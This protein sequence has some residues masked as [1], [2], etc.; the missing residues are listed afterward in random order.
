M[1]PYIAPVFSPILVLWA[2]FTLG[3][4]NN[5]GFCT[6]IAMIVENRERL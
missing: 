1:T 3:Y 5:G 4:A 6:D 2:H